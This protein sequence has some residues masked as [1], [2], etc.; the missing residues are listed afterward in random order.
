MRGARKKASCSSETEAVWRN[1][2]QQLTSGDRKRVRQREPDVVNEVFGGPEGSRH[3]RIEVN[4]TQLAKAYLAVRLR[5]RCWR[6]LWR[7]LAEAI[8]QAGSSTQ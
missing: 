1:Q 3:A 7:Y 4:V 2:L 5:S 8:A 6:V